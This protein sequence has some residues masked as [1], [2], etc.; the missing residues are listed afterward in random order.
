MTASRFDTP[1]A[2][3][4]ITALL[5]AAF[6][7][8]VLNAREGNWSA[9][10]GAGS[11]LVEQDSL[12]PGFALLQDLPGYD[13]QFYYRL[14]RTPFTAQ[15][16]ADGLTLDRPAYRQQRII[17]PLLARAVALGQTASLPWALVAVNFIAICVLGWLGGVWA[18][19]LGR[20]ALWGLAFPLQ[21]GFLTSASRDLSEI[22]ECTLL[23]G[24]LLSLRRGRFGASGLLLSVAVLTKEPALLVP[25][26]IVLA[27][28]VHQRGRLQRHT[29]FVAGLPVVT[30][31]IWQGWLWRNW[32]AEPPHPGI[33]G[34]GW[35]LAGFAHTLLGPLQVWH[36]PW[37]LAVLLVAILA[38]AVQA[39]LGTSRAS[40]PEKWAWAMYAVLVFSLSSAVWGDN[41]AFVRAASELTLLGSAILLGAGSR[42]PIGVLAAGLVCWAGAAVQIGLQP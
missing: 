24:G 38:V 39:S 15:R 32:H 35:P 40:R 13:G 30:W 42:W 4:L 36:W 34:I 6:L 21:I 25:A 1:W 7:S 17:Y 10:V 8:A 11:R 3:L 33:A 18:R 20:R 26:G 22:V 14:A 41:H 9:L 31:L 19:D 37:V 12:P 5:Y 29:W 16:T 28:L 23:L 2:P 27:D